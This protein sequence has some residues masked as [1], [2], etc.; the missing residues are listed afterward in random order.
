MPPSYYQAQLGLI[1]RLGTKQRIYPLKVRR[2]KSLR[3]GEGQAA[4]AFLYNPEPPK[5]QEPLPLS[6]T[7]QHLGEPVPAKRARVTRNGTFNPPEY[8]RYKRG[9]AITL[10]QEFEAMLP[11]VLDKDR[12]KFIRHHRYWLE[13]D[14]YL[15]HR[16]AMD[17]D[18]LGKTLL[19]ALQESGLILN[20][21]Q[22]DVLTCR[23]HLGSGQPRL[24]FT[25]GEIK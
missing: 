23:K 20:D 4:M 19:D 21:S 13:A 6:I 24:E 9:L 22:V 7:F 17:A 14:F 8:T 11:Q 16:R 12:S 15:G 18:N 25:I 10:R 3:V 5:V 1:V 2:T